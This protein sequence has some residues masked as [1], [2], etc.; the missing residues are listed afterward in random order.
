MFSNTNTYAWSSEK[1][2]LDRFIHTYYDNNKKSFKILSYIQHFVRSYSYDEGKKKRAFD[3]PWEQ[4]DI[5]QF[6]INNYKNE[7]MSC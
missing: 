5:A 6:S 3:V 7:M 4:N 1:K 2:A